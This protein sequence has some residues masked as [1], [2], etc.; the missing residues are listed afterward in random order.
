[1]KALLPSIVKRVE[2]DLAKDVIR[3]ELRNGALLG[4]EYLTDEQAEQAGI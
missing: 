4:G 3:V 2:V 1:M